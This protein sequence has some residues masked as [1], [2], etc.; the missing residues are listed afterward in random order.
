MASSVGELFIELGVEGDASK[1]DEFSKKVQK[2]A[3][4]INVNITKQKQS[5]KG[6]EQ[7][8]KTF[9]RV[10]IAVTGTVFAIEKLT[11]SLMNNNQTWLSLQNQTDLT[12]S[13]LQGYAGVASL[14]DKSFGMQ[15]AAG[16]IAQ[17]NEKLFELRLTG[18]GAKGFQIAGIN[19]AGQDAF[20]V[21]EQ[22]RERIK[23]LNNT[24]ATYLLKQ[25]GLDPKLLPML[26]MER[27]E[28]EKLRQV[29]E[30][31]QL[32]D[33][34]RK[35]ILQYQI[36]LGIAHNQMQLAMQRLTLA[37]MPLWTKLVEIAGHLAEGISNLLAGFNKLHGSLKAIIV[38]FGIWRIGATK[39]DILFKGK[40]IKNLLNIVKT[41]TGLNI[42]TKLSATKLI[43]MLGNAIKGLAITVGRALLP[44]VSLFLILEDVAV[45]L[46]GGD[47]L[48]GTYMD[49]WNKR[50]QAQAELNTPTLQNFNPTNEN[51][52]TDKKLRAQEL[53]QEAQ[54]W[55][56]QNNLPSTAGTNLPS[57]YFASPEYFAKLGYGGYGG[58]NTTN[59]TSS[60]VQ[61][62]YITTNR[63]LE[64]IDGKL[65]YAQN[66]SGAVY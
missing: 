13:K 48:I 5:N 28:F 37:L 60:V 11:N 14:L 30:R 38:G 64:D 33:E 35:Q 17:L 62:N 12:I 63:P 45:W 65:R 29:E 6:F 15:G 21:I 31:L 27:D 44:I 53:L 7:A 40:F 20:G 58:N 3:K 8:I 9:R 34:E 50:K 26:R 39:L 51:G 16:S 56:A 22:V 18:E 47:S 2:L 54:L 36:R 19:P 4:D 46:M 43:P 1:L 41:M 42:A 24:Q 23:S 55:E 49:L 25:I 57:Q 59:N 52:S 61:N 66:S 32:T 10:A